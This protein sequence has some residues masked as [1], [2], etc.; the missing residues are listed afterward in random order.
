MSAVSVCGSIG[1]DPIAL[2][3]DRDDLAFHSRRSVV[4]MFE[5]PVVA[6]HGRN[7]GVVLVDGVVVSEA[8]VHQMGQG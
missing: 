5:N 8:D 7:F 4:I 6:N 3:L 1:G 2:T